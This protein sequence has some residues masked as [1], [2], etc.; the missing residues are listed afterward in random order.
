MA[1]KLAI[2][3]D[4]NLL[5]QIRLVHALAESAFDIVVPA[6]ERPKFEPLSEKFGMRFSHDSSDSIDFGRYLKV[7]HEEPSTSIGRVS[8]PLIFP[9]AITEYCRRLWTTSRSTRYSF[10]GL[11]TN[12]RRLL[13]ESWI[14]NNLPVERSRFKN[15]LWRR[16]LSA[17]SRRTPMKTMVGDLVLWPSDRGRRFP[18][19]SWDEAYFRI[20][21]DSQFVLCPSGDCIWSYRF[22]ESILCGA[23]PI[24]EKECDAYSGFHYFSFEDRAGSVQ[25]SPQEAEFNYRTCVERLTVPKAALDAEITRIL[26]GIT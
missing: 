15:G 18:I 6:A 5:Q 20:L 4:L 8:R 9:R 14:Q 24:A 23:I 19:K 17:I 12:K 1:S 11:I 25:W 16:I 21:A 3:I 7:S 2:A 22:F 26:E 10:P 13:L